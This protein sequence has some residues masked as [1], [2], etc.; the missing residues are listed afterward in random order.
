MSEPKKTKW[1]YVGESVIIKKDQI[2]KC[3]L[4]EHSDDKYNIRCTTKDGGVAY[5]F[6]IPYAYDRSIKYLHDI[7]KQLEN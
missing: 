1:L 2:T 7:H 6:P 4:V 3:Q 5:I